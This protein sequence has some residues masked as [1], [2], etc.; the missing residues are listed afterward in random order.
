MNLPDQ[1]V[2]ACEKLMLFASCM[3][4]GG[5]AVAGGPADDRLLDYA[6]QGLLP[7]HKSIQRTSALFSFTD[8]SHCMLLSIS[9]WSWL[10]SLLADYGSGV[11]V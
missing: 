4:P 3:E 1:A 5:F 6:Y 8:S 10:L 11:L 2:Q 7:A 9:G